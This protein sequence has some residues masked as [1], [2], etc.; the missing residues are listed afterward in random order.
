MNY[1]AISLCHLYEVGYDTANFKK[2]L[3]VLRY[4]LIFYCD[5]LKSNSSLQDTKHTEAYIFQTIFFSFL[6]HQTAIVADVIA[7]ANDKNYPRER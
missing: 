5:K 4:K 3:L 1:G 6:T 2:N 7:V